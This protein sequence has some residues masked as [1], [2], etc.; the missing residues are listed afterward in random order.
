MKE[1]VKF[2]RKQYKAMPQ[3]GIV[4]GSGLGNFIDEITIEKEVA[5]KTFQISRYQQ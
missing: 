4:L 3:V 2:L 5:M 1:S